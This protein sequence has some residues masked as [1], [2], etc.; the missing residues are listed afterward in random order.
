MK[1]LVIDDKEEVTDLISEFLNSKG[2]ENDITND[3]II[4]FKKTKE[5]RYDFIL[6]DILMPE[7]S[8]I[9]FIHGLEREKRLQD[10]KIIIFSGLSLSDMEIE[11]LLKK[12]GVYGFIRKP[13]N[14]N[15]LLVS[16]T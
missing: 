16:I 8:G 4:G 15:K 6:L 11:Y 5:E 10:Q 14:F 1:V 9:D 13:I 3:P 12:Q 2:I 7:F